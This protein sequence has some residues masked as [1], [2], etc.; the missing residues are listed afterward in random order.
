MSL[1]T[2][3]LFRATPSELRK[4]LVER[5]FSA[6][7]LHVERVVSRGHTSPP[8]FWYDQPKHE[9]VLLLSGSAR[10]RFEETPQVVALKPG[11]Y[12]HI[13]AHR[14]HRVEWTAADVDT[15]WLAIHYG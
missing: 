7:S 5:I 14:R 4:E 11:D 15:V 3:N 10:V 9:W 6:G 8:G 1:E 2:G 12:L 13:P